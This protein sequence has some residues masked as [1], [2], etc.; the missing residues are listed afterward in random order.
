M[1]L[2]LPHHNPTE[3]TAAPESTR[4]TAHATSPT[5]VA[6]CER[7]GPIALDAQALCRSET[8]KPQNMLFDTPRRAMYSFAEGEMRANP[9]QLQVHVY[10]IR[11][12][13]E[14]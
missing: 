13:D 9:P 1:S 7:R 2:T 3:T 8:S 11:G 14:G 10:A 12:D 5:P 6:L 4:R